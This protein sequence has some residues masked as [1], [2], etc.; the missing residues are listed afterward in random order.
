[1]PK[2]HQTT[3]FNLLVEII[4][5]LPQQFQPPGNQPLSCDSLS[6][7][8]GQQEIENP[9]GRFTGHQTHAI[10]SHD[11]SQKGA[12]GCCTPKIAAA[13]HISKGMSED[14]YPPG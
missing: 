1:V 6:F 12:R 13:D 11:T 8:F 2:I 4:N 5:M 9:S 10:C 3:S 7:G 14:L